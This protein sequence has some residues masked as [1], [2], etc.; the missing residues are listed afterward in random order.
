MLGHPYPYHTWYMLTLGSPQQ[1]SHHPLGAC[2]DLGMNLQMQTLLKGIGVGVGTHHPRASQMATNNVASK[3]RGL[4]D[5][6]GVSWG[7][8][9]LVWVAMAHPK[10]AGTPWAS[11]HK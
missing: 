9:P 7:L 3:K 1:S 4:P 6:K 11:V 10:E 5:S 2:G 8:I